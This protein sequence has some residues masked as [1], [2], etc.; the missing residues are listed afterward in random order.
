MAHTNIAFAQFTICLRKV[1]TTNPT[2]FAI[3]TYTGHLVGTGNS[4]CSLLAGY[5]L[6]RMFQRLRLRKTP[7]YFDRRYIVYT[8]HLAD[9]LI[10]EVYIIVV[11]SREE[12]ALSRVFQ[13][14]FDPWLLRVR[15]RLTMPEQR[16]HAS[17]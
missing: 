7:V 4:F 15:V 3:M 8:Y 14:P 2:H 13:H 6:L 9:P 11:N 16:S 5:S 1:K 12:M 17:L 10:C